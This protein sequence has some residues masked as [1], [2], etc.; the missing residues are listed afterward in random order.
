LGATDPSPPRRM[1]A[2]IQAKKKP[3]PAEKRRTSP[4]TSE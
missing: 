2:L 1:L 3:L 4:R